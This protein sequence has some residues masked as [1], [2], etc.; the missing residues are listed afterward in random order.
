MGRLGRKMADFLLHFGGMMKVCLRVLVALQ[1][2]LAAGGGV[3]LAQNISMPESVM[4]MT[5]RT[6]VKR[7]ATLTLL[8]EPVQWAG[9]IKISTNGTYQVNGGKVRSLQEGQFL[10]ADG[11]L[12]NPDHSLV[13]VWDH[14]TL[15]GGQVLVFKDGDITAITDPYNLP[16]GSIV[17]PDGT[18]SRG[19]RSARLVDG[20]LISLEG[21]SMGGIDTITLTNG[22]VTVFK[23][24]AIIPLATRDVIM[25]M[26][27][28]TRVRGDGQ[29]TFTDGT[30]MQMN[31]GEMLTVPGV[32]ASW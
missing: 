18:Y 7:G 9:G 5:N 29:V 8:A 32:N 17:N 20:Q 2:L 19:T 21:Q 13:P 22:K 1:F 12:L 10:R 14:L 24:G 26:F 6:L 3:A 25:G 4:I 16:D 28:G 15:N 11:F 30:I 31:E 23:S 27:D